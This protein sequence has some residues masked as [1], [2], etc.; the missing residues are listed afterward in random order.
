MRWS[1]TL[2][3]SSNPMTST[4]MPGCADFTATP[5]MLWLSLLAAGIAFAVI[6]IFVV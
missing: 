6:G 4:G 5:R 3:S 2:G 1:P